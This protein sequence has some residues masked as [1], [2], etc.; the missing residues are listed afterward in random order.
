MKLRK[1][2]QFLV[3]AAKIVASR[4]RTHGSPLPNHQNVA[5]L[6]EAYLSIRRDGR[7]AP[8]NAEDAAAMLALLKLARMHT[9]SF[10][11]DDDLDFSGYTGVLAEIRAA[12][13]GMA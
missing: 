3:R 10:N 12:M 4:A 13:A 7:T 6:W 9:G 1:A 11:P 5:R 2:S 8:V